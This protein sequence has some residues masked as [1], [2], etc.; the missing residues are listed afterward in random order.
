MVRFVRGSWLRRLVAGSLAAAICLAGRAPSALTL[1]TPTIAASDLWL[2]PASGRTNGEAFS[3]AYQDV[4]GGKAARALPVLNRIA[5]DA[6]VGGY[7]RLYA[8]RAEMALDRPRDAAA[9]AQKI[10]A[11]GAPGYLGNAALLLAADAA[12]IGG[13][14]AGVVQALQELIKRRPL[15]PEAVY[16]RLGHAAMAAGDRALAIR[17]WSSV[18]FDYPLSEQADEATSILTKVA[19]E[20]MTPTPDTLGREFARA[21]QLFDAKR[22]TAARKAFAAIRGV[23][24][25]DDR[26]RADL[27]IAECDVLLKHT[28]P[29]IEALK[30]LQA[31]PTT[32]ATETRYYYLSAVRDLGRQDDYVVL[33]NQFVDANPGDPLAEATLYDL[34]T[35]FTRQDDD[36]RA[37]ATYAELYRRFPAGAHADRAAW[38]AG[39]WAFRN[40]DYATTI[41]TF[42]SACDDFRHADLRPSWMYWTARANARLNDREAAIACFRLVIHDYRNTYYGREAKRELEALHVPVENVVVDAA[43]PDPVAAIVPGAMPANAA[44]IRGLLSAGLYDDA[45]GELRLVQRDSGTSPLLDATMAY[46]L[47]RRGDLRP[48]IQTMRRAYPEFLAQ[49]GEALPSDILAVIFPVAYWDLIRKYSDAHKLD[50][51]IVAALIAQEST[52]EAGVKSAANAWGLMQILPSTGREYARKLGIAP[53]R[54]ARLTEPEVNIRIGTAFFADMMDHLGDLSLA[55]AAYNA[56]EDRAAR[57]QAARHGVERDEFID[58][59]P[60]PETQN[61]VKRIIGT[62]EDYRLLYQTGKAAPVAARPKR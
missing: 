6:V 34:A 52:F 42:T 58:D 61:Y 3:V 21:D 24:T 5:S 11:A 56:G 15:E 45:I 31:K 33:A 37:A 40:G 39:W 10:L 51:Y 2:A 16:L 7:A 41:Q 59:I 28:A 46:A 23:S 9:T 32:R 29:A 30:A 22:Y 50:P 55:L 25:S 57:W 62:A 18:Y 1:N 36:A 43:R 13:D 44:L 49:G 47:N 17:S 8:G 20:S 54:T 14:T 12:A 27:R 38:K 48:G 4:L 19:P 35:Y 53:F 60:Y 26:D